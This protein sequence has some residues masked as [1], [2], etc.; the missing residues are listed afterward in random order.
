MKFITLLLFILT[1]K[2]DQLISEIGITW[3]AMYLGHKKTTLRSFLV[4]SF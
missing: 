4:S 3:L 2:N 1:I